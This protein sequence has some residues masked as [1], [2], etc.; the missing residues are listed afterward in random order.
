MRM[1]S[2]A[3][4]FS[5]AMMLALSACGG[6][7]APKAAETSAAAETTAAAAESTAAAETTAA[8]AAENSSAESKA[9]EGKPAET[10]AAESKTG[11]ENETAEETTAA[12][13]ENPAAEGKAE[14]SKSAETKAEESMSAE[15]SDMEPRQIFEEIAEQVTLPD[16]FFADDDFIFNYYGIDPASLESYVFTMADSPVLADSVVILKA[17]N[18][19]DTGALAELLQVVKEGKEAEMDNY[20]PEAY[21]VAHAAEVRIEGNYIFLVM[22]PDAAAI[23]NIILDCIRG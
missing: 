14:E 18:A 21:D 22:S 3:A 8:A 7:A 12:A 23:E 13:E 6:S 9:E 16:M 20:A 10:S 15:A 4:A 2:A 17:K 1:R 5:A 19:A 11:K